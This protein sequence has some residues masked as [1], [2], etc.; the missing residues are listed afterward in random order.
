VTVYSPSGVKESFLRPHLRDRYGRY[1]QINGVNV[2][3]SHKW[4]LTEDF[5]NLQLWRDL[6]NKTVS[7]VDK[8]FPLSEADENFRKL[9]KLGF[10]SIRLLMNWESIQPYG[11]DQFD[12]DYLDYLEE[13]VD[14]AAAWG[15][16][17]LLD[18]HQDIFSR[19]L[20]VRY[21]N[22]PVGPDGK[23]Y[24][25]GSLEGMLFSL[26]P[27]FNDWQRGHGAPQ[28]VVKLCLPEKNL[29]SPH[30]GTPRALTGMNRNTGI[31]TL[32][33]V[34][35]ILK[36]LLPDSA[37]GLDKSFSDFILGKVLEIEPLDITETSDLMP[38]GMWGT[39]AAFSLDIQRCFATLFAGHVIYPKY[40]VEGK[41]IQAYLQDQYTK[42]FV[43]VAKRVGNK[44]NVIGYDLMNEPIGFYA[45]MAVIAA[46]F[47][48][49]LDSG[50]KE[51]AKALLGDDLGPKFYD[52]ISALGLL[53]PD[54]TPETMEKWGFKDAD[55]MGMISL[56]IG[57]DANF[58]QP[59]FEGVAKA[60]QDVDPDAII[61]FEHT[62]GAEQLLGDGGVTQWEV[63]Q[64][65]LAG[66]RQQVFAPHWYPDIYAMLGL[67]MPPREF[68]P[69]EWKY[70]D[71]TAPL[72]G[73]LK[74]SEKQLGNV[75]VILGEFGTYFNFRYKGSDKSG[76]D[77]SRSN[78]YIMSTYIL[79]SY[80]RSLEKLNM[81]KMIWCY[82][83]ENDFDH[84]EFW[85]HEDFSIVDPEGRPRGHLAYVRPHARA[86]S[87]QLV[88]SHFYSP[89]Q[90]LE[91]DKGIP[92]PTGEFFLKMEGKETDAP[93]EIFVPELHY[94]SGFH[95]WISD[96]HLY[97]DHERQ[98]LHWYPTNDAP[99]AEHTIRILPPRPGA[100]VR[101][102]DY[103]FKDDTVLNKGGIQ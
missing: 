79:D 20:F 57:F 76:I 102:W 53:P 28:W 54:T 7:Y 29:D 2:S 100:D 22:R 86:T 24:E 46:Y 65:R 68:T 71:F 36:V 51:L 98:L 34:D 32:A 13:L 62:H 58:L 75:P 49:G 99:G 5:A 47:Q 93:T 87:G 97:F 88:E 50:V 48:T 44:P 26:F 85:N 73:F 59:F 9:Q 83:P 19:H 81:G 14:R 27:P 67:N 18:M 17:V 1:L 61:W 12:T 80:Y 55:L 52:V 84:G 37:S 6:E 11:P 4:P 15:I 101:D 69:E 38:W 90:L 56:N 30:W 89:F 63:N 41:N 25:Q 31:A 96:G 95:A 77:A 45:T 8:P 39:N 23:A 82:S 60:I 72:E 16:Y 21:N 70:R 91:P 10:N 3:G 43:E 33:K 35:E 40:M 92:L 74:K 94:P 42:A 66:I 103:F 64:T 78:D